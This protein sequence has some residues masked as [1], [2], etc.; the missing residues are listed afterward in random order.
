MS[1]PPH[2]NKNDLLTSTRDRTAFKT[3]LPVCLNWSSHLLRDERRWETKIFDNKFAPFSCFP[4]VPK[5]TGLVCW[6]VFG[7]QPSCWN[8][9]LCDKKVNLQ[10][11]VL[12]ILINSS[13]TSARLL[14][15]KY[16]AISARAECLLELAHTWSISLRSMKICG[17]VECL[18]TRNLLHGWDNMSFNLLS[19]QHM[20]APATWHEKR[21]PC[22]FGLFSL[23][24]V[25]T[26]RL[27]WL[28]GSVDAAPPQTPCIRLLSKPTQIS[29][30][31][32]PRPAYGRQGL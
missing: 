31:T 5:P 3:Q 13:S 21:F 18:A 2:L 26:W 30:Y 27:W 14:S 1:H 7:E 25:F 11:T 10:S 23:E 8:F 12:P 19:R 32:K 22:G 28:S 29:L 24:L 20:I 16:A 4:S 9:K 15:H 17:I 6:H